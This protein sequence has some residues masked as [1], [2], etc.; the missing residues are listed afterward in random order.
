MLQPLD[1]VWQERAERA[2]RQLQAW[3]LRP[4]GMALGAVK[5]ALGLVKWG[6]GVRWGS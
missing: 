5:G 6:K 2:L 3:L 4:V 1:K